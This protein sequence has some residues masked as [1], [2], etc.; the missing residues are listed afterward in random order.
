MTKEEIISKLTVIV[1][2][3]V[4]NEDGFKNISENTDFINDLEINSANLVDIILDVEDE[5]NIEID[6]DSME[7]M[8]SVK[9]TVAIIQEKM[10]A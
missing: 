8:L 10:N 1:K 5:F 6:N 7:K 9:A 2:P 3:Y 4:Q